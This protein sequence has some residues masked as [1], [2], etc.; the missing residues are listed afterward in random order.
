[1]SDTSILITGARVYTADPRRPWAEAVLLRGSHVHYVGSEAEARERAGHRAEHLHVPGGLVTPGL[2]E[3]HVHMTGGSHA[4]TILNLEG[5]TTLPALQESLRDYAAANPE[6]P[7]IEAYGLA[8]EPLSNLNRPEREA[9]DEAVADRPVFVLAMDFHSAWANSVALQRAGIMQGADIARPS[10]VVVDPA[11]GLA[12]G[13]LKEQAR[14]LVERLLPAPTEQQRDEMLCQAI[15]HVNRLGITSVQN[16]DADLDRLLQYERLRERGAL[17]L[18]AYH[19]LSVRESTPRERLRDFAELTRQYSDSWNRTRGI[20]LFIDGVVEAKTALLLEPYADGSGDTG[21]PDMDLEVYR[22]IVVEADRLGLDIATHAIGD[23]G[24]RLALDAYEAA[25]QA[26]GGRRDRRHR[27]EHIEVGNADDIP[28]FGR[29]GV[30][31]SMQPLHAAPGADPRTTP[32]TTLVGPEREPY[33]FPWRA[34]LQ[35]GASL[36]F[37]SDWPVVTPDVRVG[38]RTALARTSM[39]G[40]PRG[41]WQ[42]QQCVTLAQALDAYTRG[43]AYAEAQD[44]VKGILRA[45]MLADVT[46]FGQD[47]FAL[48]PHELPD[49]KI[50]ATIVD[51]RIVHRAI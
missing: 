35:A 14:R 15:R 40:E 48:R 19:Y 33:A 45:G 13:M 2:N 39:D 29:L 8:Y 11:S 22:E 34:L 41:G 50:A 27:I 37:G 16:M 42:P 30:T 7:W 26:N 46:V 51:G 28:R 18:R 43:G 38:L 20:K 23:R 47:L 12:T 5:I 44:D 9:L 1:M 10:E 17:T 3:S 24:V 6:R 21:V 36:A 4:L 31:A 32:W 25:Q 49:V